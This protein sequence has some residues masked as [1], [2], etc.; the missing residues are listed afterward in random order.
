MKRRFNIFTKIVTLLVLLLVPIFLM[1]GI[2]YK[3]SVGVV[4]EQMRTTTSNRLSFFAHELDTKVEQLAISPVILSADPYVRDYLDHY[5]YSKLDMLKAESRLVE[6][7]S[8]QSISGTWSNVLTLHLPREDRTLSSAIN[9]EIVLSH[10][11]DI[12]KNWTLLDKGEVQDGRMFLR[13]FAVPAKTTSREN[14]K[15][16]FGISFPE[17]NIV[18][19]LDTFKKGGTG[20]PFFYSPNGYAPILNSTADRA[21]VDRMMPALPELI[22]GTTGQAVVEPE[23]R[24]LMLTYTQTR[25]LGW[26]LIDYMPMEDMLVPITQSRNLFYASSGLLVL[27]SLLAAF[28][29]YRNV[30]KPIKSLVQG[31]QRLK[32]GD[33]SVRLP[34]KP[35]N[36]FDFLFYRFNDMAE[37]MGN[38]IEHV[39]EERI[40][41]RE[42]NI[43][44]LQSQINPHFLFNSLFFIINSAHME[45]KHSVIAM[46]QNLAEYYRYATRVENQWESVREETNIVDKYLSIQNMRMQRLNYQI[47]IP[48]AMMELQIPRL[49]L[50]PIVENAIVHGL[51]PSHDGGIIKITGHQDEYFNRIEIEDNGIGMKEEELAALEE[52]ITQPMR[53]DVGCGTWNVHQRLL[54][55][56]GEGSGLRFSTSSY[57]G[58][59]VTVQWNR[60]TTADDPLMRSIE[61]G[62]TNAADDSG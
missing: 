47:D 19:M 14:A 37:Q 62:D 3:I 46:A 36:E 31:V 28:L 53:E 8:L 61:G 11:G 24:K 38:L 35:D 15:A 16:L 58:L 17:S 25:Q 2:S 1:Y 12:Y 50:Q 49:L 10:T 23:G 54:V 41:S 21:L 20:D 26:Y 55:Q 59:K 60:K 9:Q 56:F 18:E 57:G 39:Y 22:A 27:L 4:E 34:M 7:L 30:Q 43:K 42:A 5:G 40:R 33:F 45:D 48:A 51:E 32:K 52:K 29:L 13:E 44:Q 6:K